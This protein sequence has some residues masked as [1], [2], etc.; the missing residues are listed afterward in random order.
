[1]CRVL[2]VSE[3]SYYAWCQRELSGRDQANSILVEQIQAIHAASR[4]TYGSP[5]IHAALQQQ[6][7]RCNR[8]RVA[9]LMRNHGIRGCDRRRRRPRTT[10]SDPAQ[11][12]MANILGR[13]FTASAPNQIWL[14][15]I[16][17]IDTDEG[18][19]YLAGLE[20]ACSRKIIGWCMADHLEVSLV[21]QALNM[22][23]YQRS[24]ADDLV[25]HSDRGSH[26]TPVT[27][28]RPL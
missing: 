7:I 3:S 4:Q 14:G 26:N 16:T 25:H 12:V 19:L 20:D 1:M 18:F 21:H 13:D 28:T 9:R 5:R 27:P 2:E 22:A 6:G 15:D 10:Q 11:P 24:L 23:L 8:K 17:Y